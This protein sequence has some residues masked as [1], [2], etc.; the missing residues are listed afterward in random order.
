MFNYLKSSSSEIKM[1]QKD[2]S[3]WKIMKLFQKQKVERF[4]VIDE[5]NNFK[6]IISQKRVV[7]FLNELIKKESPKLLEL[8]CASLGIIGKV[9]CTSVDAT[10]EETILKLFQNKI[11]QVALIDED[12][13]LISQFSYESLIVIFL[14]KD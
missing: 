9:Y 12:K 1:I 10:C 4:C 11:D 14:E 5:K 3:I 7:V 8:T 6:G 13:N 2:L